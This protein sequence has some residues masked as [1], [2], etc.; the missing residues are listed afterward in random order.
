MSVEE[1]EIV[2]VIHKRVYDDFIEIIKRV[3]IPNEI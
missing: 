1:K 2:N 3:K